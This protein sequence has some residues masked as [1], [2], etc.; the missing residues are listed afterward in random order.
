M[1]TNNHTEMETIKT[2]QE[3][4]MDDIMI[5]TDLTA[6]IADIIHKNTDKQQD[7]L[8]MG[9]AI[10]AVKL[11]IE[12]KYLLEKQK[13]LFYEM[14]KRNEKAHFTGFEGSTL[15][16]FDRSDFLISSDFWEQLD[17]KNK[18]QRMT[19]SILISSKLQYQ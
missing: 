10:E 11:T 19:N 5:L 12:N 17:N 7:F 6:H 2:A 4:A 18:L 13:I 15:R 3:W 14:G 16:E 1:Q 9:N 8:I